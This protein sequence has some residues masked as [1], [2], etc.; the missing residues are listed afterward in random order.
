MFNATTVLAAIGLT[1]QSAAHCVIACLFRR[2][3]IQDYHERDAYEPIADEINRFLSDKEFRVLYKVIGKN[4]SRELFDPGKVYDMIMGL[5]DEHSATLSL[6][7]ERIDAGGGVDIDDEVAQTFIGDV[8]NYI[9]SSLSNETES[10]ESPSDASRPSTS[11][12][13]Q[14]IRAISDKLTVVDVFPDIYEH[15]NPLDE[16]R[17][18]LKSP[19]PII[20]S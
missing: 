3:V 11:L 16:E 20:Y 8:V 7:G 17:T 14:R 19:T 9:R 4:L 15:L 12:L 13:G 6:V 10:A 1:K 2:I 18:L 5:M